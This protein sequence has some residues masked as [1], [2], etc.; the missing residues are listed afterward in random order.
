MSIHAVS[1]QYDSEQ[2]CVYL[3]FMQNTKL[4]SAGGLLGNLA[5]GHLTWQLNGHGFHPAAAL[6]GNNLGQV[7]HTH[8]SLTPSGIIW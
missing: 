8:V 2:S 4:L 1:L 5:V 7:V 6:S 3:C